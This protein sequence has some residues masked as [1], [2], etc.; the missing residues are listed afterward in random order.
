MY[1]ITHAVR[2]TIAMLVP[3]RMYSVL[4]STLDGLA[5]LERMIHVIVHS[6]SIR[7]FIVFHYMF[8]MY[9]T[10]MYITAGVDSVAT[11]T[12]IVIIVLITLSHM[13][14]LQ[15]WES[16]TLSYV[17]EDF[18]VVTL[19]CYMFGICTLYCLIRLGCSVVC[20]VSELFGLFFEQYP[21]SRTNM[22]KSCSLVVVSYCLGECLS[23]I[24]IMFRGQY[25]Y[26]YQEVWGE[27]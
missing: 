13:L 20:D 3:N 7:C 15:S 6:K 5:R 9:S 22:V 24:P 23:I 25:I 14:F 10:K 26:I 17:A 21:R 8:G 16:F 1:S 19:R 11:A 18:V 4:V 2:A 12:C 27:C